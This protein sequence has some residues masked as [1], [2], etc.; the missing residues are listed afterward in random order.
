MGLMS[1]SAILKEKGY[2]DVT[3]C[4]LN[5]NIP[6]YERSMEYYKDLLKKKPDIVALTAT[7]PIWPKTKELASIARP[8]CRTIILG[9]PHATLFREKVLEACP[10]IDILVCGEADNT[11]YNLVKAID[12]KEKLAVNGLIY[13]KGKKIIKNKP[14]D[15]I[16]NLDEYPF[17]DRDVLNI[18]SY[19]APLSILTSRGCPYGC[20]FCFKPV[21]GFKWRGRSAENVVKEIEYLLKK[22]PAIA[23]GPHKAISIVDDNFNYDIK[24]AKK[25]CDMIT[26]KELDIEIRAVNGFHVKSV[27]LELFEKAKKAGFKEIWF[28]VESGNDEILKNLRKGITKDDVRRAVK[29]AKE[30]GIETIG[31]HFII[32]LS[33]ETYETAMETVRFAEE[34]KLDNLGFNHAN[35]LPGTRL[36]D[37]VQKHG[38]I[39][40]KYDNMDFTKFR[41]AAGHPIFETPEFTKEDRIKAHT[42]AMKLTT[43][44]IRKKVM[45]YE[46]ILR[47][48]FRKNSYKDAVWAIKRIHELYFKTKTDA[49]RHKKRKPSEMYN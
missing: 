25:I 24:R 33:G 5:A 42:E 32:G 26:E 35:I 46:N 45:T 47:F 18:N 28:G 34:L 4:D 3:I 21:T 49:A 7:T 31:A 13:R 14:N 11:I 1:L 37:Y 15:Y 22:Y 20:E 17:P 41:Q 40:Y 36:W 27:D 29:L 19:H 10:E 16:E 39:L 9:G 43:K 8:H 48:L 30:A 2:K 23:A 44:I 12:N 6:Y 38:T